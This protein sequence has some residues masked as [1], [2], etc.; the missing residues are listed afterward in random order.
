MTFRNL[1]DS[2]DDWGGFTN[3][4]NRAL[5]PAAAANVTF[6]NL[7]LAVLGEQPN[8]NT[9]PTQFANLTNMNGG[10]SKYK[11]HK[12]QSKKKQSKLKVMS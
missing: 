9:A 7:A 3:N 4:E 10:F 1:I 8:D 11:N 12:K 2:T 6:D 5:I